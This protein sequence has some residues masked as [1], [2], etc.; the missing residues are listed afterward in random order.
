MRAI[1]RAC[2]R[3]TSRHELARRSDGYP[4]GTRLCRGRVASRFDH[5]IGTWAPAK[6]TRC[7]HNP[8]T[9]RA[10]R[11]SSRF[12]RLRHSR[13]PD[14]SC[15]WTSEALPTSSLDSSCHREINSPTGNCVLCDVPLA[16]AHCLAPVQSG[17]AV[18][19]RR[20]NFVRAFSRCRRH[21]SHHPRALARCAR[22][23]GDHPAV[24]SSSARCCG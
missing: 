23:R 12:G 7:S 10:S 18:R 21:G 1:H 16:H 5:S 17:Q 22:A 20:R 24:L 2:Y 6:R 19:E 3:S 14:A 9:G 8:R 4:P 11:F 13:I 15:Q